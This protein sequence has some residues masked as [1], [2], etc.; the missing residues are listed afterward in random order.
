MVP[1]LWIDKRF[2]LPRELTKYISLIIRLPAIGLYFF[3][4]FLMLGLILLASV[5]THKII[6]YKKVHSKER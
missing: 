6:E 4:G 5:F 1:V 3:A 2:T